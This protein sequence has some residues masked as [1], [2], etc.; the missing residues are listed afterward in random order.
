[1]IHSIACYTLRILN[2]KQ[3]LQLAQKLTVGKV[4]LDCSCMLGQGTVNKATENKRHRRT[5]ASGEN[6]D[7]LEV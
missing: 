4:T 5:S 6:T 7:Y 1:M 2:L 3:I